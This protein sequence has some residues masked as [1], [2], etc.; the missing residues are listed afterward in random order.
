MSRTR[1]GPV[2]TPS[3]RHGPAIAFRAMTFLLIVTGV[4][5]LLRLVNELYCRQ[6]SPRPSESR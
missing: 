6:A 3:V 1:Q 5:L 2:N 4:L